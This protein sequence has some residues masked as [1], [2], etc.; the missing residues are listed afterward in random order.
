M[1]VVEAQ[2]QELQMEEIEPGGSPK[3][4]I[5][6]V[7]RTQ[8]NPIPT[9]V[10]RN[11]RHGN[12]RLGCNRHEKQPGEKDS[13]EKE[14]KENQGKHKKIHKKGQQTKRDTTQKE[15]PGKSEE[16]GRKTPRS[17]RGTNEYMIQNQTCTLVPCTITQLGTSSLFHARLPRPNPPV[18]WKQ[19]SCN[20]TVVH[21]PP[22]KTHNPF[23]RICPP[24]SLE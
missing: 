3:K 19:F 14:P 11:R 22:A 20:H 21:F 17:K 9:R 12:G 8:T 13:K 24:P 1:A 7:N 5:F 15:R 18:H 23:F 6:P 4:P 16:K 2:Q 10:S